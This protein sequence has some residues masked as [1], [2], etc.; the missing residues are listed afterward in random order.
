MGLLS[1]WNSS[2]AHRTFRQ[3]ELALKDVNRA[4]RSVTPPLATFHSLAGAV[5]T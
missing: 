3:A 1:R 5:Q 2:L 4:M